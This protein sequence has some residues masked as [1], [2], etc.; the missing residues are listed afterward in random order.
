PSR[1]SKSRSRRRRR[2]Q[3][4]TRRRSRP[5]RQP[6]RRPSPRRPPSSSRRRRS[7]RRISMMIA[8]L[9]IV[10]CVV[11]L[12]ASARAQSVEAGVLFRE[13]KKLLKDGKIAEACDKLEASDRI[14][15]SPGTLLNLADCREK[16]HQLATAWAAFHKAA[17]AAKT[18]GDTKRESEARRREKAL[19]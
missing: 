6:S 9:A 13:G 7:R 11:G 5:S 16:N 17:A 15:S 8:R 10:A 12:A 1:R 14:E 18:G 19:E 3:P 2:M 4:S